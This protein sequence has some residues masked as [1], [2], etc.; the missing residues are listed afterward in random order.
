MKK[1]V[2]LLILLCVSCYKPPGT[3]VYEKRGAL[4]QV[5]EIHLE[6]ERIDKDSADYGA[7]I[8]N[9]VMRD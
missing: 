1:L 6:I 8:L 2:F 4:W 9:G 5:K 3:V 7:T